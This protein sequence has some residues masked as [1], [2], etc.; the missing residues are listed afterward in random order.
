[1]GEGRAPTVGQGR[2]DRRS[3]APRRLTAGTACGILAPMT[4]ANVSIAAAL[5][6]GKVRVREREAA[7]GSS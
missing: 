3:R 6:M 1:M 5:E 7:G 2:Q 4:L